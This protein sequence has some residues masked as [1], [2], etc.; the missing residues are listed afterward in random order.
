MVDDRERILRMEIPSCAVTKANTADPIWANTSGLNGWEIVSFAG[1]PGLTL[2]W[3]GTI[4]LSGY[5]RDYKTFYPSG[6]V[7]QEGPYYVTFG[8]SAISSITVVSSVPIDLEQL[9]L[10]LTSNSTPGLLV[11]DS[12][13]AGLIGASAQNWE[14]TLFC[15]TKVNLINANLPALGIC[16]PLTTNQTGSMMPTAAQVLYVARV[17]IPGTVAGGTG[18]SMSIPASRVILPGSMNQEPELEY[19]MRLSRSVE[20]ANQV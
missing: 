19:M 5:A 1:V 13:A 14:T 18:T 7:M 3:T 8:G 16:Q 12:P 4:D 15:E 11:D 9:A 20:L 10:T 17:V 2:G 6:G